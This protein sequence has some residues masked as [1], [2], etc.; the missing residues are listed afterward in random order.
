MLEERSS[1]EINRNT[2][3]WSHN[4]VWNRKYMEPT[5]CNSCGETQNPHKTTRSTVV[6]EDTLR[7]NVRELQS[8]PSASPPNNLFLQNLG[9]P[10]RG[11]ILPTLECDFNTTSIG[12]VGTDSMRK[13]SS[14]NPGQTTG[15]PPC[16]CS[17]RRRSHAN[18]NRPGSAPSGS[19]SP[20]RPT[21]AIP[22]RDHPSS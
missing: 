6:T 9:R 14:C 15:R 22:A 11:H 13:Q 2:P 4:S 20:S 8:L 1:V 21:T 10:D 3:Q 19:A 12:R 17:T 16:P 7:R 5:P 18:S